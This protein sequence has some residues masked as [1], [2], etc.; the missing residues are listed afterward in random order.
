MMPRDEC[1]S[2]APD[3]VHFL[4]V[5]AEAVPF[6]FTEEERI[7]HSEISI[8]GINFFSLSVSLNLFS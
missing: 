6:S 3:A 5:R 4:P 8:A 7:G 2:V 1:V